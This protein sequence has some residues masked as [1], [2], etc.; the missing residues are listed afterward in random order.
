MQLQQLQQPRRLSELEGNKSP[1]MVRGTDLPKG[2]VPMGRPGSCS[3]RHFIGSDSSA[4]QNRRESCIELEIVKLQSEAI[5]HAQGDGWIG[6]M[7]PRFTRAR[8][9]REQHHETTPSFLH[10]PFTS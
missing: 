3:G 7:G 9:H 1:A 8:N 5:V 6:S 2:Q 4:L 10:L